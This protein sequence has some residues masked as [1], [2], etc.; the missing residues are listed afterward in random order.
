[1]KLTAIRLNV[2]FEKKER[3]ANEVCIPFTTPKNGEESP[4]FPGLV[5]QDSIFFSFFL[6]FSLTSWLRP[7]P[8]TG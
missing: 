2:S 7:A 1:V 8:G 3:E 5:W 4:L 6:L